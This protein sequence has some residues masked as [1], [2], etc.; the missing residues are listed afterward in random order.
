ML[1]FL[2]SA[3]ILTALASQTYNKFLAMPADINKST[4]TEFLTLDSPYGGS[5]IK[6][7]NLIIR[8]SHLLLPAPLQTLAKEFLN[9]DPPEP[10]VG[11]ANGYLPSG[12]S[13][14]FP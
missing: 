6:I 1:K 9:L 11:L 13:Q 4:V 2:G 5:E 7:G 14:R 12:G 8:D 3:D 10:L